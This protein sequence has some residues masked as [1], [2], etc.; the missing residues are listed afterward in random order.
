MKKIVR[1][2]FFIIL[3]IR[4][5]YGQDT[6]LVY[7]S[8]DI[9]AEGIV[10]L[11]SYIDS[12]VTG[13]VALKVHFGEEGNTNFLSP[14][15]SRRMVQKYQATYVET[16]VLYVGK[17]RYTATHKKLAHDHGFVFADVDILDD[18]GDT[19]VATAM[20]HY[21]QVRIPKRLDA[22]DTYIIFSHFKGHG[23]AGFGGAI[24]NVGMGM[25][26]IS[27]KMAMHASAVPVLRDTASCIRCDFCIHDCPV[28]AIRLNPVRIDTAKCIGCGM[29]I[30]VCPERIFNVP[31]RSTEPSVFQERLVEY[32]K[33]ILEGRNFMYVNVLANIARECDCAGRSSKPFMEDIGVLVSTDI[34]AIEEASHDLV[35]KGHQCQDA[36]EKETGVSG[37][38]QLNYAHSIGL[39]NKVYKLVEVP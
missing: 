21:T 20:K 1:V 10:R 26:P 13:K 39:G 29:C 3:M 33:V 22:Y 11:F 36:F 12:A 37:R 18:G 35:N 34:L 6:T 19:T 28:D 9:S 38:T 32:T 17:R 7:F 8:K 30:G 2:L 23:S 24:K 5:M 14:E 15:L 31:W 4:G 16:N 25:A 27:G